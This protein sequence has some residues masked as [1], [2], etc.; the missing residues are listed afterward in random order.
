M[1]A[2]AGLGINAEVELFDFR[3][4]KDFKQWLE[5]QPRD[6]Q[7]GILKS[8]VP[9]AALRTVPLFWDW[10]LTED[11]SALGVTPLHFLGSSLS[12]WSHLTSGSVASRDTARA[13]TKDPNDAAY[14]GGQYLSDRELDSFRGQISVDALG[15]AVQIY[16]RPDDA[17]EVV[18]LGIGSITAYFDVLGD[19]RGA[20]LATGAALTRD[21][22]SLLKQEDLMA[23]PLWPSEQNPLGDMWLQVRSRSIDPEW[24]FWIDWYQGLLD[25]RT[26]NW[27]LLEEIAFIEPE[28][29][30][31]GPQ[32]VALQIEVYQKII[33]LR[34]HA[35]RLAQN[36]SALRVTAASAAQRS[37]N[38]PPELVDDV[39]AISAGVT[40]IWEQVEQA[41]V[42]LDKPRPDP[43]RLRRIGK[44]ILSAVVILGRYVGSLADDGLRAGAKA[45]GA[46]VGVGA[47]GALIVSVAAIPEPATSFAHALKELAELMIKAGLGG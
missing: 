18:R 24:S 30:D 39:H 21:C 20:G 16:Q 44:A 32:A 4:R 10:T 2:V 26:Q 14:G 40:L 41:A 11:P 36:V 29:W 3:G 23:L 13:L 25:G 47:A 1:C 45:A 27:S 43:S 8:V 38:D 7:S 12:L 35:E 33:S 5:A 28:V 46:A 15:T 17:I 9:R 42:E 19:V 22:E 37:H 31:A 6:L 34:E